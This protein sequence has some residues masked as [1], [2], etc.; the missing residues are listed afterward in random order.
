MGH[1]LKLGPGLGEEIFRAVQFDRELT[2]NNQV[3]V[4]TDT[5]NAC[6]DEATQFAK[7]GLVTRIS[8]ASQFAGTCEDER[9]LKSSEEVCQ[10]RNRKLAR[11]AYY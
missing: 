7:I 1:Q 2:Q 6:M 9:E 8:P 3:L 11:Y 5:M 4:L 10:Q